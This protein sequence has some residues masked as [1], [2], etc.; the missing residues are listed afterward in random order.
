MMIA[1]G[2]VPLVWYKDEEHIGYDKDGNRIIRRG[3]KDRLDQLLDRNDAARWR[4]VYDEYNDEEVHH[5][6]FPAAS[7]P[8]QRYLTPALMHSMTCSI[9]CSPSPAFGFW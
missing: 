2:D 7:C 6:P 5:H 4:T 9:H 8:V 3:G 1:V